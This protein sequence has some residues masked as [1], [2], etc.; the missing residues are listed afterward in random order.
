MQHLDCT[1]VC[2]QTHP[3][4]KLQDVVELFAFRCAFAAIL[5]DGSVVSW[6]EAASRGDSRTIEAQLRNVQVGLSPKQG[7]LSVERVWLGQVR[8]GLSYPL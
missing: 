5:A 6:G 3:K 2:S 1:R 8:S 7:C 4:E